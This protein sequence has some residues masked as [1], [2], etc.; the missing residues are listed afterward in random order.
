M[1]D[2]TCADDWRAIP[3]ENRMFLEEPGAFIRQGNLIQKDPSKVLV[4]DKTC[5][6]HGYKEL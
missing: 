4:F 2:C 6:V 1:T 5:P 3:K